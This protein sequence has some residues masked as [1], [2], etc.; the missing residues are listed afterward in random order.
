L[1][2]R[3]E[4]KKSFNKLEK[5][6]GSFFKGCSGSGELS[7]PPLP[8]LQPDVRILFFVAEEPGLCTRILLISIN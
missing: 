7:F 5:E 1:D 4:D 2:P 8:A 6:R 3:R